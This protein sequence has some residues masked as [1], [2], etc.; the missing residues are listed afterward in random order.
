[1]NIAIIGAGNVG[2]S[3]GGIWAGKG[4]HVIF[5]YSRDP[6]KLKALAAELPDA[7]AGSPREAVTKSEIVLLSV[8]WRLV[9][10]ALGAVGPLEGKILID[11]VNP[12]LPDFSGLEIGHTTSA[13]EE[14][15]KLAPGARVVKA[16]NTVFAAVYQSHSRLF[17]T[18]RPM[19][20]YC[21]DDHAAKAATAKLINETGFS[22]LDAGPL[23]CARYLEPLAMLM[24]QMA[25]KQGM[26][27]DI[28]LSLI[29][30]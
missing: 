25:Y 29:N 7:E 2:S 14:I 23:A 17:G 19:M 30:R 1:M 9:P 4:H 6:E 24:I 10:E 8:P 21:G 18:R 11:C 20:F 28:S 12:L 27:T 5:S 15:S 3:L 13:A 22:P 26:G 16:F